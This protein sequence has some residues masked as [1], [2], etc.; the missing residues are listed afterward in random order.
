MALLFIDS[1]DHYTTDQAS[2]KYTSAS[3]SIVTGRHGNG[4]QSGGA[5]IALAPASARCIVGGAWKCPIL[6]E[7]F[8][9]VADQGQVLLDVHGGWDGALY[10][11]MWGADGEGVTT[12]VARSAVDIIK[13]NQWHFVELDTT[14]SFDAITS[15]YSA[16]VC[17]VYVDGALVINA[18]NLGP[19]IATTGVPS[20]YGWNGVY[21]GAFGNVAVIDDFYVLDGS[22]ATHNAPLGDVEIGVIRP[23]GAGAST[24]WTPSGAATNWDATNDTNPDDDTT[25]VSAAV[26]GLSDLYAMEDVNTSDGIIGAQLLVNAKRTEEGFASLTPLLRHAGTTTELV[27]RPLGSSYFYRNRDVFVTMPNGD[28]LTD[29]NMNALQAGVKRSS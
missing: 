2:D 8:F 13:A 27:T 1:F 4:M 21:H 11:N 3:G 20:T 18:T 7:T 5:H 26:A 28:P 22:G 14:I 15:K 25:K 24:Q 12:T 9:S 29:V 6:S 19:T 23:N 17:K 10:V 16:T